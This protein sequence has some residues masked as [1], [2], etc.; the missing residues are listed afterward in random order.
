[1]TKSPKSAVKLILFANFV[2]ILTLET[3]IKCHTGTLRQNLRIL[4]P[5]LIEL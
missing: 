5:S 1:M 4:R 3:H 2:D